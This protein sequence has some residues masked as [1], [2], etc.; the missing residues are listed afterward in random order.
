MIGASQEFTV[1]VWGQRVK[2]YASQISKTVWQASGTYLGQSFDVKDR[3][4]HAAV[5]AWRKAAE[6]RGN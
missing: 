4:A 6:Y 3:S 1:E 5:T 2:V